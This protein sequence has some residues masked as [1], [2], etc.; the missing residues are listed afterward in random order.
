[1][2]LRR[3]TQHENSELLVGRLCADS[4]FSWQLHNR[5]PSLQLRRSF[6]LTSLFIELIERGNRPPGAV[7]GHHERGG[8]VRDSCPLPLVQYPCLRSK[9]CAQLICAS[10]FGASLGKGRSGICSASVS[11][12]RS[13]IGP[14]RV[15]LIAIFAVVKPWGAS[16]HRQPN[17]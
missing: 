11:F 4:P 9:A 16:S 15:G 14:P 2:C 3:T 17:R 1:M 5:Y 12:R 7:I 8:G 6:F 13:R 10:P